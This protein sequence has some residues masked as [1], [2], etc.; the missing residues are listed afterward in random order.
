MIEKIIDYL[1][2]KAKEF[3]AKNTDEYSKEYVLRKNIKPEAFKNNGAYFGFIHPEEENSGPYHDFSFVVFPSENG[4]NWVVSLGI[5]S[6]GF[7]N[8]YELATFPGVR[9][10]FNSII[11]NDENSFCKTDFSDI[12]TSLPKSFL[13]NEKIASIRKTLE[14]YKKVLP[15]CQIIEAPQFDENGE[16]VKNNSIDVLDGF[17]AAKK[18]QRIK[19]RFSHLA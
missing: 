5:G 1:E 11:S 16:I 3:G 6:L 13:Q 12:E 14:T 18:I 19:I 9:R 15:V 8:D 10:L 4:E 2:N 17:L 7:K